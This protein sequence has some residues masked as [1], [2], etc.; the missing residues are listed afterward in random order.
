MINPAPLLIYPYYKLHIASNDYH[1]V[2]YSTFIRV[3]QHSLWHPFFAEN[4]AVVDT[5]FPVPP[6]QHVDHGNAMPTRPRH[7]NYPPV[8]GYVDPTN[9]AVRPMIDELVIVD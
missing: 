2:D 8:G 3:V 6:G 5:N 4:I 1:S 9:S 7:G